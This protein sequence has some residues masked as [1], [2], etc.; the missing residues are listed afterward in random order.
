[1]RLGVSVT[2]DIH[3]QATGQSHHSQGP[4]LDS[5]LKSALRECAYKKH[6]TF[7]PN[8]ELDRVMTSKNVEHYLLNSG[9]IVLLNNCSRILE[10]VCGIPG[11]TNTRLTSRRIFAILLIIEEP[12]RIMDV[13][14]GGIDDTNLPFYRVDSNGWECLLARKTGG[15]LI[16]IQSL[17]IWPYAQ[18]SAFFKDQWR[19][20]TPVF[21]RGRGLN[22]H[23]VHRLESE[24]VFPW[25]EYE[26]EY[27]GNSEVVRVKIHEAHCRFKVPCVG[28]Q[29]LPS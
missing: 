27:D 12:A 11:R 4:Y 26:R 3:V 9:N 20:Q 10:S 17:R 2:D 15:G 29:T 25:T 24:V 6:L 5:L 13:I 7:L 19:V 22:S 8:D 28:D 16:P 1:M 23:P 14:E 18:R 21:L